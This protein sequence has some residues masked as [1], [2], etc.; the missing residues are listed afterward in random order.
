LP[1]AQPC[2]VM[3]ARLWWSLA[4]ASSTAW[5]LR[6]RRWGSVPF[7]VLAILV[8]LL[9]LVVIIAVAYLVARRW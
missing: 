7:F 5:L 1:E 6:R 9:A 2:E 8:V 3:K 4:R